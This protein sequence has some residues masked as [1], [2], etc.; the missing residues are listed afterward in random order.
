MLPELS[1]AGVECSREAAGAAV[2]VQGR[3]TQCG[4]AQWEQ[5]QVQRA[6]GGF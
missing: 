3:R 1:P 2:P 6:I 5:S 4:E